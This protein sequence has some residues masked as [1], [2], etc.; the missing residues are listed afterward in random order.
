MPLGRSAQLLINPAGEVAPSTEWVNGANVLGRRTDNVKRSGT[1]CFVTN[2][3][4]VFNHYQ[5]VAITVPAEITAIDAGLRVVR[6]EGWGMSWNGAASTL[7]MYLE[8]LDV[9]NTVIRTWSR[10][11]TEK[12]NI[13][14]NYG[15]FYVSTYLPVGTRKLRVRWDG[16]CTAGQDI[17]IDDLSLYTD[18]PPIGRSDQLVVNGLGNSAPAAP[19]VNVTNVMQQAFGSFTYDN[20]V[21]PSFSAQ[22]TGA[23][24]FTQDIPIPSEQYANVDAGTRVIDYTAAAARIFGTATTTMYL[25]ALDGSSTVLRTWQVTVSAVGK[26]YTPLTINREQIPVG[27][28]TLRVGCQGVNGTAGDSWFD[29]M[30]LYMDDA[31]LESSKVVGYA[32]LGILPNVMAT[33]KVMAYAVSGPGGADLLATKVIAYAVLEE[34]GFIA[35]EIY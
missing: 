13:G 2:N 1:G 19:W 23:F 32:V 21:T 9:S 10:V 7:T 5:D 14:D 33:P 16:N 18:D 29:N 6:Y 17:W 24:H 11:V 28:R 8:A 22:N 34:F 26:P 20:G 27:T 4:A 25:K 15:R 35:P 12:S 3:V 31:V 30:Q